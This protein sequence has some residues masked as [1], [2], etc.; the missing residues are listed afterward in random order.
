MVGRG[1]VIPER[2]PGTTALVVDVARTDEDRIC[3]VLW[4][5]DTLGVL[6]GG[7]TAG[8]A[9]GVRLTAYLPDGES[10]HRMAELLVG[11]GYRPELH[12]VD[13]E[14]HSDRWRRHARTQRI[15]PGMVVH[16][17]WE[18]PDSGDPY[19]LVI[20]IEPGRAFGSGSHPTTRLCLRLLHRH[21]PLMGGVPRVLDVG[22]GTGVLA[23]AAALLGAG[24]VAVTETDPSIR[25]TWELNAEQNRVAH[26]IEAA[27]VD[28]STH[29]EKYD[30]TMANLLLPTLRDL[31][32][33]LVRLTRGGG[34]L[35]VSGILRTQEDELLGLFRGL[36]TIDSLH[37]DGWTAFCLT[38]PDR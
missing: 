5:G 1:S 13:P 30:L 32:G 11:H 37:E 36:T 27:D 28:L 29:S 24:S 33:D 31:S 35:I 19:G 15:G 34:R 2:D 14:E 25:A 3:G 38:P 8:E 4:S 7:S 26:V 17:P 20:E 23:I 6:I 21:L 12:H 16:P 18:T 10:A 22:T 9:E